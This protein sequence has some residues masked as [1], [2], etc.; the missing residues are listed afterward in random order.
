MTMLS[1]ADIDAI[2]QRIKA[3]ETQTAVLRAEGISYGAWRQ[4]LEEQGIS[5]RSK[6]GRKTHTYAKEVLLEVQ[7]R[8]RSGEFIQDVCADMG[9]LYPNMCRACRRMGI[10]I[11]DSES[12]RANIRRRKFDGPKRRPGEAPKSPQ[13]FAAL[14][15]G[16]DIDE[17]VQRF[18]ISRSYAKICRKKH[19]DGSCQP[20]RERHRMRQQRMQQIQD[21]QRE[22]LSVQAIAERIGLN[23]QYVSQLMRQ[24]ARIPA[25][26]NPGL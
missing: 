25:D 4:A 18:A 5:W 21:L 8:A 16:A 20:V 22:G 1:R 26:A 24:Q 13:I 10:Q 3:G 12:L 19:R 14:D 7:R 6:R 17:L 9:L 15:A 2:I 11:L 23:L